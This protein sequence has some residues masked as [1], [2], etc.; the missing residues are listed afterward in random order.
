MNCCGIGEAARNAIVGK[1][2]MRSFLQ[3][4]LR[5]MLVSFASLASVPAEQATA[6]PP[7]GAVYVLTDSGIGPLK[8]NTPPAS[9]LL[10]LTPK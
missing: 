9:R 5:V 8:D 3:G 7:S 1:S 6:P 10:K 2:T 4:P